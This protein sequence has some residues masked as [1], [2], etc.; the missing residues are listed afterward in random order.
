MSTIEFVA[1]RH[2]QTL[3]EILEKTIKA[4]QKWSKDEYISD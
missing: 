2:L 3:Y 4:A 1:V